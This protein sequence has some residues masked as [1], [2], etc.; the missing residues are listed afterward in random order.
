LL[1]F[2]VV[3]PFALRS[4]D[5]T[6]LILIVAVELYL[7]RSLPA[8]LTTAFLYVP[9]I[10]MLFR[11]NAPQRAKFVGQST[12]QRRDLLSG[13]ERPLSAL[14]RPSLVARRPKPFTFAD[15]PNRPAT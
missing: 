10:L 6:N 8:I 5:L 15:L 14:L 7:K 2:I 4:S 3:P 12:A 9:K 11:P 13:Q 1:C